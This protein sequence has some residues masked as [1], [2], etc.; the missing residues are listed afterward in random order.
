MFIGCNSKQDD[1]Q[2]EEET[3]VAVSGKIQYKANNKDVSFNGSGYVLENEFSFMKWESGTEQLSIDFYDMVART[4]TVSNGA[5]AKGNAKMYYYA[6]KLTEPNTAYISKSGT[7]V[8]TSYS[9]TNGF[10]VSGTFSASLEKSVNGTF[11]GEKIEITNGT[12]K[13]IVLIDAR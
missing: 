12:F 9:T 8:V 1:P 4:Y 2:P 3:K 6:N 7:F 10:K 13:D 5:R 11:N